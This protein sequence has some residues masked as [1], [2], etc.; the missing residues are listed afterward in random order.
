M[1]KLITAKEISA[2]FGISYQTINRY[3]DAGLLSVINK[4][5]NIRFYNRQHAA[6]RI[7]QIDGLSRQGYSLLLIR[8]KLV[9]I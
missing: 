8:R 7:K 5:G 9:G 1:T 4:K 6:K 2:K 3:T